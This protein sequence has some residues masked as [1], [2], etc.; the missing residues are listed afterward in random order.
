MVN[1]KHAEGAVYLPDQ[2]PIDVSALADMKATLIKAVQ[3][4]ETA[5]KL[6][7]GF[8]KM[9]KTTSDA[10]DEAAFLEDAVNEKA[11]QILNTHNVRPEVFEGFDWDKGVIKVKVPKIEIARS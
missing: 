11:R 9:L 2:V 10:A 8:V 6:A 3:A 4:Q 1:K 7:I 5:S